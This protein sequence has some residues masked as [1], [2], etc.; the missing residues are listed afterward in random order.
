MDM[1]PHRPKAVWGFNGTE[2][3]GAVYLAAAL[4]GH[5]QKA[6]RP[7]ASMD[8]MFRNRQTAVF[9]RMSWKNCSISRCGLAVVM[10]RGKSYLAMGGTS[11]GI[12]GLS[13][14]SYIL[15]TSLGMR[16]ESVDMTEFVGRMHQGIFDAEEYQR[17][18][19]WVQE[20]CP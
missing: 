8:K 12:A 18:L 9:L 13:C 11:M 19:D 4:A 16:V 5:S 20:N 7:L 10:M 6:R 1:D 2:R 17:A 15:E 14:G 3:P